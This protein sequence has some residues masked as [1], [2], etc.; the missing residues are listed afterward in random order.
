EEGWESDPIAS[1]IVERYLEPLLSGGARGIDTLILGC[2]HYPAL[3]AII[4]KIAGN[5]IRLVD[6]AD[7]MAEELRT[8][9]AGEGLGPSPFRSQALRVM[10][11]DTAPGF[12]EVARRLMG[13]HSIEGLEEVELSPHA[14]G[15]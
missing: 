9:M 2:T 3:K 7:A 13:P 5:E 10:T 4:A 1:L 6:G 15:P 11:T 14:A 8:A 12:L